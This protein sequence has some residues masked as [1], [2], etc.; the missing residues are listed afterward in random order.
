MTQCWW[1]NY[2]TLRPNNT[3]N[4]QTRQCYMLFSQAHTRYLQIHDLPILVKNIDFAREISKAS[5]FKKCIYLFIYFF[6][7]LFIYLFV[8]GVSKPFVMKIIKIFTMFQAHNMDQFLAIIKSLGG[9][10]CPLDTGYVKL[11]GW[12][13]KCYLNKDS[14]LPKQN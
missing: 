5:F 14:L 12:S 13:G 11:K 9:T 1:S 6:I 4:S 2:P 7:Y 3:K 10:S 8:V